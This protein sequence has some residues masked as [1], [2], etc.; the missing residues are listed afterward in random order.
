VNITVE[1]DIRC[2]NWSQPV[3]GPVSKILVCRM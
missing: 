2:Q 3:P 1:P